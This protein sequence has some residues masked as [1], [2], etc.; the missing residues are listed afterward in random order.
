MN[1]WELQRHR[2]RKARVRSGARTS[3]EEF[4]FAEAPEADPGGWILQGGKD[5]SLP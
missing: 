5:H 2:T 1:T 4:G 3:H